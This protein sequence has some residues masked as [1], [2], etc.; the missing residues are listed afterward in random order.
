MPL[1]CSPTQHSHDIL[2]IHMHPVQHI[3][4]QW[5]LTQHSF[6]F[7]AG[8]LPAWRPAL[9]LTGQLHASNTSLPMT[10]ELRCTGAAQAPCFIIKTTGRPECIVQQY[11]SNIAPEVEPTHGGQLPS[12][13]SPAASAAHKQRL[14]LSNFTGLPEYTSDAPLAPTL[15]KRARRAGFPALLPLLPQLLTGNC[16]LASVGLSK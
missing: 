16:P 8:T 12:A 6:P 2:L 9:L 4:V 10:V 1:Q 13:A 14:C 5:P 11:C 3:R 15:C 7:S